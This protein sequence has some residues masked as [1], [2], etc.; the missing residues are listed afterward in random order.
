MKKFK[1]IYEYAEQNPMVRVCI[2]PSL[3]GKGGFIYIGDN[4]IDGIEVTEKCILGNYH[5]ALEV[6]EN[7]LKELVGLLSVPVTGTEKKIVEKA[8]QV[9]ELIVR[10]MNADEY[11]K[12]WRPLNEREVIISTRSREDIDKRIIVQVAG[13]ESYGFWFDYEYQTRKVENRPVKVYD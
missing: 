2:G 9:K 4:I 1:N 11:I 7:K 12:G 10:Y 8:L 3:G 6:R 13:S 5:H